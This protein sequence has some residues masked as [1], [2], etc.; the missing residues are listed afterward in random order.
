MAEAARFALATVTVAAVSFTP[1]QAL[2]VR[3]VLIVKWG[4]GSLLNLAD[5]SLDFGGDDTQQEDHTTVQ[6]HGSY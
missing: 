2:L 1:G 5:R 4:A 6:P 3:G